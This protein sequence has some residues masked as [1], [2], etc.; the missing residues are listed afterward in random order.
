[1]HDEI[2]RI[3]NLN[4][5]KIT[6]DSERTGNAFGS[7]EIQQLEDCLAKLNGSGL[8]VTHQG[9]RFFCTGGN[10]KE[11]KT[12]DRDASLKTQ[13]KIAEVFNKISKLSV[14]TVAVVRGDVFGGG[15]EFLSAFDAVFVSPHIQLGLWQRRL[16]VT[17]GWG[18]GARLINRM[19]KKKLAQSFQ[20]A[21][22]FNS[23]EAQRMGLVD[24]IYPDSLVEQKAWQWLCKTAQ[25]PKDAFSAF[26]HWKAKDEA[27]IFET[28]WFAKDHLAALQSALQSAKKS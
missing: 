21:K 19:G 17:F 2:R 23:Y 3:G 6:L 10:L 12:S 16:G 4:F 13:R 9:R 27:E 22:I 8:L 20:S 7:I 15:L 1:M 18:G 14:P 26:R 24:E 5:N 25:L 28:L 11:Q